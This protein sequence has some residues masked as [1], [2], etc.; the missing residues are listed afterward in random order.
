[1]NQFDEE[2]GIRRLEHGLDRW[3]SELGRWPEAERITAE[4]LLIS[5]QPARRIHE[6]A[7]R[8]DGALFDLMRED[9]LSVRRFAPRAAIVQRPSFR[10]I[11]TWGSVGLAAS[12]VAGFVMGSVVPP[13]DEEI[14]PVY[15]AVQ[16]VDAGDGGLL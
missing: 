9:T 8:V 12:L 16:D 4:R 3:G 5:S 1:M 10:R 7:R 13:P 6:A 2:D 15:I 11:A 14:G